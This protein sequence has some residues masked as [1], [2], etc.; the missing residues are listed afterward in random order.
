MFR[1]E[2][3]EEYFTKSRLL[4]G[5]PAEL[6]L[7]LSVFRFGGDISG[8]LYPIFT[9]YLVLVEVLSL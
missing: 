8:L 2:F 5:S 4:A 6:L 9:Q 7:K 3:I 1:Q